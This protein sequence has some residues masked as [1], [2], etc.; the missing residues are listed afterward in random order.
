MLPIRFYSLLF[1]HQITS[2]IV[3]FQQDMAALL[4]TFISYNLHKNVGVF[5]L[6]PDQ[7]AYASQSA[8]HSSN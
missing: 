8:K 6:L 1:P 5:V 3:E 2:G 4:K 7:S